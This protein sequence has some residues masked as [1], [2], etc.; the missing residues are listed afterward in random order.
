[1]GDKCAA[2][3]SILGLV[4]SEAYIQGRFHCLL[5]FRLESMA[6]EFQG[7]KISRKTLFYLIAT[8]NASF[9]PDYDFSNCRGDEFSKEPSVKVSDSLCLFS[10]T[11]SHY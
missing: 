6:D 1:M 4:G 8:L 2:A 7:I 5:L 3:K 9:N 11:L 10:C